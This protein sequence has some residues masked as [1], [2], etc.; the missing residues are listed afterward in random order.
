MTVDIV[1]LRS[2]S[3]DAALGEVTISIVNHNGMRSARFIKLSNVLFYNE[4][5]PPITA[6]KFTQNLNVVARG[7]AIVTLVMSVL[8][9]MPPS[10]LEFEELGCDML[11]GTASFELSLNF[12]LVY[13]CKIWWNIY[14]TYFMH[15][16]YLS[17]YFT[18]SFSM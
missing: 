13:E 2:G 7:N 9:T 1:A 6:V 18:L 11:N 4:L 14:L 12:R 17:M 15:C 3:S 5:Y 16:D 8:V 10:S